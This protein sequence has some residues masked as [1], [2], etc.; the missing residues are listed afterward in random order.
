MNP[1]LTPDPAINTVRER[2]ANGVGKGG[3]FKERA[4]QNVTAIDRCVCLLL[5]T[6]LLLMLSLMTLVLP[7]GYK[8]VKDR[9]PVEEMITKYKHLC[10]FWCLSLCGNITSC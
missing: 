8:T 3:D 2:L 5:I 6:S 10:Y 1:N 7:G 4:T 9:G